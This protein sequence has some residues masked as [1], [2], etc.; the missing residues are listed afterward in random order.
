MAVAIRD[1]SVTAGARSEKPPIDFRVQFASAEPELTAEAAAV[2]L[3]I[4]SRHAFDAGA[5][6]SS[7]LRQNRP[8]DDRP[9]DIP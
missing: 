6:T 2:L 1:M 3:R 8:H 5:P 4:I 9:K 7:E